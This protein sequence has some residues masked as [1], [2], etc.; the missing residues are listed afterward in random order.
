MAAVSTKAAVVAGVAIA[1]VAAAG[2]LAAVPA[3]GTAPVGSALDRP[4]VLSVHAAHSVLLGAARAG[5]RIV[6]V[7]ERGIVTLSDNGGADWRQAGTPVSITLT[8]VRFADARNGFAVGHGGTVLAT[9]DGG[10]SWK[11][12]LDGRT[13]AGLVLAEAQAFGDPTEQRRAETLVADGPDK[14]FLDLM[15]VDSRKM[16]VVGAYG[17]AFATEDGGTSWSPW[18]ERLDN[19]SGLHLYTIRQRGNRVLVAGETGLVRL[20]T[21]GGRSF[22][23]LA[24]PYDG[25]FFT[26]ELPPDGSILLAGMRGTI[27]RS[28]DDGAHW[29]AV[30]VPVPASIN[31]SAVDPAGGLLLAN[32][33][34]MVLEMRDGTLRPLGG[35]PL[36][37]LAALLPLD[38]G[39]VLTLGFGGAKLV[40]AGGAQ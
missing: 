22:A 39:S 8:G 31:A 24:P 35:P 27:W 32:Q 10:E 29:E 25:T 23:R 19:P 14:P 3:A 9:A 5:N 15:V 21:D 2:S 37:P 36:P 28:A 33:A 4:A 40:G 11:R 17:L 20:S 6:A 12:R 16:V 26:A 18:M 1:G 13:A 34:G 7:G 30:P 38:D